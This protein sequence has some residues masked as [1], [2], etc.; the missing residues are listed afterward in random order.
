MS[1]YQ[2]QSLLTLRLST[3][4]SLAGAANPRILYKK[5]SGTKGYWAATIDT[6]DLVYVIANGDID[7]EGNWEFQSYVEIGGKKGFGNIIN[8]VFEQNI[9][10]S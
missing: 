4:M 2:T 10:A 3:G 8:Q 9:S 1:L 5:P 7:Q 6:Q